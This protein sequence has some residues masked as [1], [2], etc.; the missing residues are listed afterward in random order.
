MEQE[1]KT[2][3]KVRVSHHFSPDNSHKKKDSVLQAYGNDLAGVTRKKDLFLDSKR[4]SENILN[5]IS[6]IYPKNEYFNSSQKSSSR[7]SVDKNNTKS[8][9]RKHGLSSPGKYYE[10]GG[11]GPS[12]IGTEEWLAAKRKQD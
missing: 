1:V 12:T 10:L 7:L 5:S 4:G 2:Q 11:L 8:I 6:G 3:R 9:K